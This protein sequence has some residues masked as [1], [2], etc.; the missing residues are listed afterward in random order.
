MHLAAL[1]GAGGQA[2]DLVAGTLM[3][4]PGLPAPLFLGEASVGSI[5]KQEIF[6]L[7]VEHDRLG[8][9]FVAEERPFG[10]ALTGVEDA[11]QQE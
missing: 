11:E 7:H 2:T 9:C 8:P 10:A 4:L 3:S 1:K 6:T 5:E